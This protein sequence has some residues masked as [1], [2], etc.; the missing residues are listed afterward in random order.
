VN[1]LKAI[2]LPLAFLL[3]LFLFIGSGVLGYEM[4]KGNGWKYFLAAGL[5]MLT[6][7]LWAFFAAPRSKFRLHQPWLSVFKGVLFG[8]F[9]YM[10]YR[11]GHP[12]LTVLFIVTA[13][14]CL[15]ME[16]YERTAP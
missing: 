3:E 12:V 11:S 7:T 10:L 5:P 13:A 16:Y 6:I 4:G 15:W 9:S 14:F 2:N 8:G 1:R